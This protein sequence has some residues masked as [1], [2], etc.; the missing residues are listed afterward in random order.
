MGL[1]ENVGWVLKSD[2]MRQ[3]GESFYIRKSR[4]EIYSSKNG[5]KVADLDAR[6]TH[7]VRNLNLIG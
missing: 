1:E 5:W 3:M 2:K 7:H 6:V 4:Y